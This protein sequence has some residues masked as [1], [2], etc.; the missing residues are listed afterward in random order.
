MNIGKVNL[1]LCG[2]EEQYIQ[3]LL[4][5]I[6]DYIQEK[7]IVIVSETDTKKTA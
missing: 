7:D 1:V 4:A 6:K 2:S 5:I 3:F